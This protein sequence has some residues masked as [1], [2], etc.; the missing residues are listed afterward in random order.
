MV[1]N[2]PPYLQDGLAAPF[3]ARLRK[4]FGMRLMMMRML[5]HVSIGNLSCRRRRFYLSLKLESLNVPSPYSLTIYGPGLSEI[6]FGRPIKTARVVTV[7]CDKLTPADLDQ[8]CIVYTIFNNREDRSQ[9]VNLHI[10][11]VINKI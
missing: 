10:C 8:P 2:S 9:E 11:N 3:S 7:I 4:D 5:A 1:G 6:E